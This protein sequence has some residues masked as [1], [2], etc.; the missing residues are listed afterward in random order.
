MTEALINSESMFVVNNQ[1]FRDEILRKQIIKTN[2]MIRV[3]NQKGVN[4]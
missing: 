3:K 4:L 1:H 2:D